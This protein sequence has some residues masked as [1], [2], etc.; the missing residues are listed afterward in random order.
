MRVSG[1]V[2]VGLALAFGA[3]I[4]LGTSGWS[5]GKLALVGFLVAAAMVIAVVIGAMKLRRVLGLSV[6]PE[7]ERATEGA[8][9]GV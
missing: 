1:I 8:R 6:V 9:V 7:E 3:G 2:T 5:T 4:F